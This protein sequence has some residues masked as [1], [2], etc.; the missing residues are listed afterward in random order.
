M[1][2]RLSAREILAQ[3]VAFPTVSRDTN[4][5]LIDWVQDYLASWGVES[6]RVYDPTGTKAT[7]FAS[8]GPAVT[9]GVMLSGHV[10][11]V[12][13]DGQDWTSDPFTLTERDGRL[14]GRGTCDMKGFD[15]LALWA[16]P[17][18][19][20]AG[21]KRPLQVVLSHDEEQGCIAPPQFLPE[22]T[23]KLPKAA[24][25]IVGEPSMMDCVTGHKGGMS[26]FCEFR[27]YEVHSSLMDRGVSAIMEGARLIDWG[28]AENA[29]LW[30]A[31]PSEL[32]AVFDPPFTT[33]H[34]GT[35]R[36]G[37]AA[38][39]TAARC[40]F[41]FGYRLVPGEDAEDLRARFLARLAQIEAGMK[42]VRPEAGVTMTEKFRVPA[43]CPEADGA[44]EA[45]VRSITGDNGRHVVSYGT[46]AGHFQAAG[47]STV[48]CGPGS[49]AQA[50]QAD[51]YLSL[52][53]LAAGERFI[54][55]LVARLAA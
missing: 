32:A 34:T 40:A 43:L 13:V 39:I 16:V 36:G 42:A 7:L 54:E 46:E 27:G 41:D 11:V 50:H 22:L 30:S 55:R 53:Q 10:D 26:F 24:A 25:V 35:I 29:R 3:L 47:F 51:E 1:G 49:I 6:H 21:V 45:L 8:A 31:P 18:A 33:V 37:T 38:N 9:G 23:A 14:F 15:A 52:A 19:L 44:A 20:E 48:V 2:N 17:L 5:P 28:N 12:P 4:L